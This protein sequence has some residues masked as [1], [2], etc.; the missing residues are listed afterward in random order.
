MSD[1]LRIALSGLVANQSA[2]STTGHNI[3]SAGVDGFSRQ[4][5]E[6]G[7][8]SP[9]YFPGGYIGRGVD[10]QSVQRKIG[11]AHV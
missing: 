1:L 6:L 5:V 10:V 7:T 9:Q 11:R 4:R 2:M 8:R 3:A